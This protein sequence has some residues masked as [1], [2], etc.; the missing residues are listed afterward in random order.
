MNKL[1]VNV[2]LRVHMAM[3]FIHEFNTT[4]EAKSA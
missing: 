4:T 2:Y 3:T 1:Y